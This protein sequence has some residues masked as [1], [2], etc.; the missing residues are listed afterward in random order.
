[1]A[2]VIAPAA[3]GVIRVKAL[4][5]SRRRAGF[6]FTST[7]RDLQREELGEGIEALKRFAMILGDPALSV[8]FVHADGRVEVLTEDEKDALLAFA[9]AEEL[10]VDPANPPAPM[11]ELQTLGGSK[12][13]AEGADA[14]VVSGPTGDGGEKAPDTKGSDAADPARADEAA[15][16]STEQPREQAGGAAPDQKAAST[17]E[18]QPAET[19]PAPVVAT[20]NPAEASKPAGEETA[21][22]AAEATG[23]TKSKRGKAG[24]AGA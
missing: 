7:P 16:A 10:R 21:S 4:Q 14:P 18:H 3:G 22:P 2:G 15:T 19:V 1:M 5:P 11:T 20:D 6:A 24:S 17:E 12:P 23:N 13:E 9:A 8:S